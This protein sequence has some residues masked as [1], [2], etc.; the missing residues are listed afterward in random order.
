ML[1]TD[2]LSPLASDL[3]RK[4]PAAY[5]KLVVAGTAPPET[6]ILLD[7]VTPEQLLA[8]PVRSVVAAGAMLC[9]LWLWHDGL[10]ECHRIAQQSPEDLR[11]TALE[12]RRKS[13]GLPQVAPAAQI[14]ET[15]RDT[16]GKHLREMASTLAFWHAIMHRREGDFSNSKYWYARVG[17]HPIFAAIGAAVGG[18]INPLPADKSLLRLLRDGWDPNA[19]VD[20]VEEVSGG[21]RDP[22]LPVVVAVQQVEWHMLFEHC[23]RAA[24]GK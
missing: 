4:H 24:G 6:R 5:Q 12:R 10:E 11:R 7:G 19:F 21:G 13:A 14:V 20:L 3:V 15:D 18:E 2:I 23:T 17:R 22:R 16:D 1:N 8:V 9:G